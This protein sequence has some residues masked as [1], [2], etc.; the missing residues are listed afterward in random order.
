MTNEQTRAS[1]GAEVRR[2]AEALE[3]ADIL[4]N[5]GKY[6]DAVSRAYYAAYHYARALLLSA[7]EEPRTHGGLDRL[8]Q[9]DFVRTGQLE[10]KDARLLAR[11]MT[12]RQSA[13]YGVWP[14]STS[15]IIDDLA[16]RNA[17]ARSRAAPVSP[18]VWFAAKRN[19]LQHQPVSHLLPN[20]LRLRRKR[21][22][23][24]E[25]RQPELPVRHFPERDR[26]GADLQHEDLGAKRVRAFFDH[27]RHRL[28][29]QLRNP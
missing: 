5:A 17:P 27:V 14:L 13:D 8:L 28:A 6:A 25:Q 7:G 16:Q 21:A 15:D 1:I 22:E 19:E 9:R 2:G 10:A 20:H 23:D 29:G 11:L 4:L 18:D 24:L 26:C 3:S 12:F